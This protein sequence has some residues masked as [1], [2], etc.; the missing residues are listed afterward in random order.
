MSKSNSD[1]YFVNYLNE[2]EDVE[3]YEATYSSNVNLIRN[4][5]ATEAAAANAATA[6]AAATENTNTNAAPIESSFE[7]CYIEDTTLENHS[8]LDNSAGDESADVDFDV[9]V[10]FDVDV[11]VDPVLPPPPSYAKRM[12]GAENSYDSIEDADMANHQNNNNNDYADFDEDSDEISEENKI[13]DIQSDAKGSYLSM[14][15]AGNVVRSFSFL[16]RVDSSQSEDNDN[17]SK[18]TSSI[19]RTSLPPPAEGINNRPS[20]LNTSIEEEEEP[21]SSFLLAPPDA[22]DYAPAEASNNIVSNKAIEASDDKENK[23]MQSKPKINKTNKTNN[24]PVLPEHERLRIRAEEEQAAAKLTSTVEAPPPQEALPP[25]HYSHL[26]KAYE[27]VEDPSIPPLPPAK[28][29]VMS[30]TDEKHMDARNHSPDTSYEDDIEVGPNNNSNES[31][32]D[33]QSKNSNRIRPGVRA[34]LVSVFSPPASKTIHGKNNGTPDTDLSRDDYGRSGRQLYTSYDEGYEG[35]D[36][37]CSALTGSH[38]GK[39]NPRRRFWTIII[40]AIALILGA[41]IAVVAY[42][43]IV[44]YRE[45]EATTASSAASEAVLNIAQNTSS[46]IPGEGSI[47]IEIN[48]TISENDNV[49][50]GDFEWIATSVPFNASSLRPVSLRTPTANPTNAPSESPTTSLA[51]TASPTS[52]PTAKPTVPP[53][54]EPSAAPVKTDPPTNE[55]DFVGRLQMLLQEQNY[56]DPNGELF[57]FDFS[58]GESLNEPANKALVYLARE[59]AAV[60]GL[61]ERGTFE[62][63]TTD[64][65]DDGPLMGN[66]VVTVG[67]ATPA[68]P[69]PTKDPNFYPILIKDYDDDKLIRRFALLSLQFGVSSFEMTNPFA[70]DDMEIEEAEVTTSTETS[71]ETVTEPMKRIVFTEEQLTIAKNEPTEAPLDPASL[72]DPNDARFL[73]DECEWDGVVCENIDNTTDVTTVTKIRWDYKNLDGWIAPTLSLLTDLVHLDMSNNA[74]KGPI[75]ESLYELTN[76]EE[77]YLYKNELSGTLSTSIGNLDKLR[78]LHLSHNGFTG[79]IPTEIKSDAGSEAGIRPIEY[80]N[81][82]SNQFTGSIPDDLRWR[83]CVTFDVGRNQL[84]GTLPEDIGDRFVEL[85]H[86]FLSHNA[87]SGTLPRSYNT[88]G[89]GRLTALAIESNQLTGA[90]PGDRE[91]YDTLVQ[92]TLHDNQFTRLDQANCD[93]YYLVEFKADCPDVC[94]CFGRFF[95]FCDRWCE[96]TNPNGQQQRPN[97][98]NNWSF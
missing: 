67:D 46:S 4:R 6:A 50:E 41:A 92:Y 48:Q 95:D 35:S 14:D 49:T 27:F 24:T 69:P 43:M 52:T 31:I 76:L 90:V 53:T 66:V 64:D 97:R 94:T 45:T 13:T 10:D 86:L 74:L 96:R 54:G 68:T 29:F 1:D 23:T 71:A 59:V 15:A 28:E 80:F 44:K 8:Q 55:G 11:D 37:D 85:R 70:G 38:L 25:D 47:V 62:Q 3:D 51:P 83:Q 58:T 60:M 26:L 91:N 56:R 81:I 78:R 84:T 5:N 7:D 61:P 21:E 82:Y 18:S 34:G 65:A 2:E 16:R 30:P 87:F 72:A 33:E 36:E 17:D 79:S 32:E 40:L 42:A 77:I 75:P 73:V 20:L 63:P 89:N 39:R 12:A 9:H 19:P 88:V 57:V 22:N 93:N 98:N